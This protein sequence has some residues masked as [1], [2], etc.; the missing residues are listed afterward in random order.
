MNEINCNDFDAYQM[1]ALRTANLGTHTEN[2][3]HAIMGM[4]GEAGEYAELGDFNQETRIGEIGDCMWY[5]AFLS[6]ELKLLFSDT[7]MM[8]EDVLEIGCEFKDYPPEVR[9]M[10]WSCRMIDVIKKTVFY[11]K[12]PDYEKIRMYLV[13]YMA[14]IIVMT[15]ETE[16]DL[17]YAANVNIRKLTARYPNLVFSPDHAINRDYDKES[18]AAG[19]KIV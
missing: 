14:A 3:L 13:R 10:L 12:D 19:V 15:K 9:A 5:S 8:A 17:L 2:L 16:V 18:K 11:G 1:L 4:S 6:R 7:I